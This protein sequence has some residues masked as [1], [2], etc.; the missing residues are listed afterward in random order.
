M[1]KLRSAYDY[2]FGINPSVAPMVILSG[3]P[4]GTGVSFT[5]QLGEVTLADGTVLTIPLSTSNPIIMGIGTN[6][7]TVTPSAVTNPTPG[8]PGTASFTATTSNPHLAGD[9][10]ASG[11]VGVGEAVAAAHQAGGG[12]V[13]VDSNFVQAGG[14]NSSITGVKGF[15]NVSIV[16]ARGTVSGSA[17]SYKAASNGSNYA[18]TTVSWY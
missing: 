7:E 2:A 9:F 13:V 12:V 8:A 5:V 3:S 10:I 15:T 16:D 4:A 18:A 11:S 14:T 1:V 6:A 17:F